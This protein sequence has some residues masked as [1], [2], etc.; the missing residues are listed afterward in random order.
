M[1]LNVSMLLFDTVLYCFPFDQSR[2]FFTKLFYV[3]GEFNDVEYY[4]QHCFS[5][6]IL[7]IIFVFSQSIQALINEKYRIAMK[8]MVFAYAF[9]ILFN[10]IDSFFYGERIVKTLILHYPQE[11]YSKYIMLIVNWVGEQSVSLIQ[12]II[13][14]SLTV[15]N[16]GYEELTVTD[17]LFNN[18][19]SV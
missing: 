19:L 4:V 11:E 10:K 1:W 15:P 6:I 7:S 14:Y 16:F 9:I 8:I 12:V 5:I 13:V 18:I 3:L 17:E 2:P